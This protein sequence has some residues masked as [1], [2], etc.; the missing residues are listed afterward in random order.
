MSPMDDHGADL[1]SLKSEN[2]RIASGAKSLSDSVDMPV[3]SLCC[4]L[5][6]KVTAGVRVSAAAVQ[7]ADVPCTVT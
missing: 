1:P 4:A 5:A 7:R 2:C 3:E 6:A